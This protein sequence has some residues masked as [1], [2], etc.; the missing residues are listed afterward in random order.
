MSNVKCVEPGCTAYIT[1]PCIKTNVLFQM[2]L[3]LTEQFE[4]AITGK[5]EIQ[6]KIKSVNHLLEKDLGLIDHE[7]HFSSFSQK[8]SQVFGA[9]I[10]NPIL[11]TLV[12]IKGHKNQYSI[13]CNP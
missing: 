3:D 4:S 6:D 5:T 9:S 7:E 1:D 8:K 11:F 13:T 2:K 12:C 10:S